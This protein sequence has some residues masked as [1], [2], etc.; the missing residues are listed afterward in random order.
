MVSL[1]V[2]R[3]CIAKRVVPVPSTP[4]S[5]CVLDA[6]SRS[7]NVHFKLN[8][9]GVCL[10]LLVHKGVH[11][12]ICFLLENL[13][14]LRVLLIELMHEGCVCLSVGLCLGLSLCCKGLLLLNSLSMLLC[15]D[16]VL[17]LRITQRNTQEASRCRTV[18]P[19]LC[20]R[21]RR[22]HT[23]RGSCDRRQSPIVKEVNAVV[24]C[25]R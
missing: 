17:V 9:V 14:V 20:R 22:R 6:L 10:K 8:L 2:D 24:V 11:V 1:R 4:G 25:S 13:H 16:Q 21:Q 18:R 23:S 19:M 12:L 3:G 5:S 7:L 15:D